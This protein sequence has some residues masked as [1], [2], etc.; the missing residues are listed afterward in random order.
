MASAESTQAYLISFLTDYNFQKDPGRHSSW[1]MWHWVHFPGRPS[2]VL[3]LWLVFV[4]NP[5][6]CLL[7]AG[8]AL[9]NAHARMR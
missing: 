1:E 2:D 4:W 8:N 5:V 7:I 9:L 3:S 6:P